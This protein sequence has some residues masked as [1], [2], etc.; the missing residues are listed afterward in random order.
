M[1]IILGF[2][3]AMRQFTGAFNGMFA[4]LTAFFSR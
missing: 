2:M 4:E 1:I 3:V